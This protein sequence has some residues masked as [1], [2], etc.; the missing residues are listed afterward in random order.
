MSDQRAWTTLTGALLAKGEYARARN[1]RSFQ[2]GSPENDRWWRELL[3]GTSRSNLAQTRDTFGRLLDDVGDTAGSVEEQL[4]AIRLQW[5]EDQ[6]EFNWRYYLVKYAA[7]RE[8]KSGI[9]YGEDGQMGYSLCMLDRT[10]LNS[11]YRDPFLLAIWQ[12]SGV[13][14]AVKDPWFMGYETSA[15]WMELTASGTKKRCVK[16]GIALLPPTDDDL[17]ASFTEVCERHSAD[18]HVLKVLRVMQSGRS[19]DQH[20]RIQVGAALLRD[21]VAEGL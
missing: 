2:F 16:D 12:E 10:Q 17:S 9:Y 19:Y 1:K 18:L 14:A 7:M 11:W 8:G 5:L 20:D 21:L 15:R 4:N 6:K 3:T 13:R